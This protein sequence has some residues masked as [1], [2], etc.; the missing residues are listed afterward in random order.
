MP[1]RVSTAK[2]WAATM[3]VA[4]L[5]GVPNEKLITA[6]LKVA[7][8][9]FE[10]AVEAT[11]PCKYAFQL[12]RGSS[13]GYIHI[14]AYIVYSSRKRPLNE[15]IAQG[16]KGIH[17]ECCRGSEEENMR[18]VTKTSDRM[19]GFAPV[20]FGEFNKKKEEPFSRSEAAPVVLRSWQRVVVDHLTT[21]PDE[22]TIFWVWEDEGNTGKSFLARWLYDQ[23]TGVVICSGKAAD[24]ACVIAKQLEAKQP[25]NIVIV[26]LPRVSKDHFSVAGVESIKNGFL[27]SSKYESQSLRFPPPHVICFANVPPP[28]G[29]FS[30]DRMKV[31]S[32]SDPLPHFR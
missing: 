15:L 18:Y 32:P 11:A 29:A 3:S 25:I 12:E 26:D 14:Q 2:R 6:D 27:C 9:V 13:T 28:E 19:E 1:P 31:L 10:R 22:R 30:A 16:L 17:L 4:K 24:M 7:M 23:Y 20:L 8:A 5:T 21:E